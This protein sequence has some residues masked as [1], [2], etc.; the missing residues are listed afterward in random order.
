VSARDERIAA[1]NRTAAVIAVA[2]IALATVLTFAKGSLVG[3]G[4]EIRAVVSDANQLR[5]GSEVRTGG[6]RVG[7]VAGIE[8]GPSGTAILRLRIEDEGRPV[9]TDATATVKPR[10]VLEGNG[11]VD[12]SPGTPA[13]RELGEGGTIPLEQTAVTPQLDQVLGVFDAPTRSSLHRGIA[14]LAEGLGSGPPDPTGLAGSGTRGLRR[15][16]KELE[17]AL[18][19][20]TTVTRAMRGT[21]PGDLPRA[22]RSSGDVAAQMSADPRALADSVTAFDRVLGAL[23]DERRALGAS[24]RGFDQVLRVAPATLRRIDAALPTVTRFATALRPALRA[25]PASLRSA[26][27]LVDEIDAITRPREL[28]RLLDRLRPVTQELPRL[29]R[30]LGD[31]FGYTD[32]VTGCLGTHVIPVLDSK[33]EDGTHTTGDPAWL[34]LLHAVTGFTSA[35]TSFDGNGGT[36]R[37]GLA[38]GPT[39]LDGVVPGLGTIA[40]NINQDIVGVRP[41][42]LGYGVEPPYRP[43]EKCADQ[44]LPELN[45]DAGPAPAWSRLSRAPAEKK[46]RP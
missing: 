18:G 27:A 28:P 23:S 36:F 45:V 6:I 17:S 26:N 3:S 2:L 8:A 34:D 20:I 24:V 11:Y 25:A 21:R 4:H 29:E 1:R 19:D 16:A 10:L 14:G 5:S 42:W 39:P 32:Q 9:R 22:I 41:V 46:G 44:K 12:L 7:E 30:R 40:G 31:L 38:F 43:D 13:A 35:S 33:I 15:A 37:A